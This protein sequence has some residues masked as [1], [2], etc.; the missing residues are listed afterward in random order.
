MNTQHNQSTVYTNGHDAVRLIPGSQ[1]WLN[2]RK[3]YNLLYQ[4]TTGTNKQTNKQVSSRQT[5]KTTTNPSYKKS[6]VP[7][8]GCWKPLAS[9]NCRT[10]LVAFSMW[11]VQCSH[12][13]IMNHQSAHYH[14]HHQGTHYYIYITLGCLFSTEV[15]TDLKTKTN[16]SLL[17]N[18]VI[19]FS[20]NLELDNYQKSYLVLRIS[21]RFLEMSTNEKQLLFLSFIFCFLETG[22]LCVDL[23]T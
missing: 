19:K 15:I 9:R 7:P 13:K 3:S 20:E 16:T 4:Y 17:I 23:Y 18:D 2:F 8:V 1:G 11:K 21:A 5:P 6:G 22:F 10:R 12:S 14:V